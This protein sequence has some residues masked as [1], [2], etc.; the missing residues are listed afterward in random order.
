MIDFLIIAVVAVIVGLA[1]WYVWKSVKAGKT[2]IGC[3]DNGKCA[4]HGCSGNCSG[5]SGACG[6]CKR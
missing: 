6:G 4:S 1:G 3:P 2:C 5:C